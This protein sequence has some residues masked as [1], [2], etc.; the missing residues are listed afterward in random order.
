MPRMFARRGA[1]GPACPARSRI[2]FLLARMRE[3][4]CG[5]HEPA[6]GRLEDGLPAAC[7]A[8]LAED[9]RDVMV[10]GLLGQVQPGSETN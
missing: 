9:R 3:R 6:L 5:R 7:D 1:G 4:L 8:E 10:H 2:V